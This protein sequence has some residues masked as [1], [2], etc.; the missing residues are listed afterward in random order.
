[1]P[2]G[3]TDRAAAVWGAVSTV[4]VWAADFEA[5]AAVAAIRIGF[6]IIN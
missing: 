3:A 5:R 6:L 4:R 1:M 2:A